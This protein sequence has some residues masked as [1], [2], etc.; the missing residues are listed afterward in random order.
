MQ[1]SIQTQL[2]EAGEE[3]YE[4]VYAKCISA[5]D[6]DLSWIRENMSN[7]EELQL[8]LR[9]A[10]DV[11]RFCVLCKSYFSNSLM[12]GRTIKRC[13]SAKLSCRESTMRLMST[14]RCFL[15][16]SKQVDHIVFL[17]FTGT[18]INFMTTLTNA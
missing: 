3:N 15:K 11:R 1:E 9:K 12:R 14:R 13:T 6:T 8:Q 18:L 10:N 17:I 2:I 5:Y 16:S 4:M 7:Q